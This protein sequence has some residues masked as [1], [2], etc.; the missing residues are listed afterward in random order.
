MSAFPDGDGREPKWLQLQHG[1]LIWSSDRH[2]E[3]PL[4]R[5]LWFALGQKNSDHRCCRTTFA[6]SCKLFAIACAYIIHLAIPSIATLEPD[7]SR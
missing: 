2:Q 3:A 1:R 5:R 7:L 6:A 4:R